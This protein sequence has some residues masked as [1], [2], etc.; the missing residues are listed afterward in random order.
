MNKVTL[1]LDKFLKDSIKRSIVPKNP[2][3]NYK[4][5]MQSALAAFEM[6]NKKKMNKTGFSGG[7]SGARNTGVK[8]SP[9]K[10]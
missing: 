4:Q 8:T 2:A 6:N 3:E 1:T 7:R 10:S 9:V 5:D